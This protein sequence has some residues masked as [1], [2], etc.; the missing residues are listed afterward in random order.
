[1]WND[2]RSFLFQVNDLIEDNNEISR[3]FYIL[4][5]DH[6]FRV[7]SYGRGTYHL[8]STH[9]ESSFNLIRSMEIGPNLS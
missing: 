4:L 6:P 2:K 1:M 5:K 3:L 8:L 7:S 9:D